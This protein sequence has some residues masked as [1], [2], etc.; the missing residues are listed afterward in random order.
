MRGILEDF[1]RVTL[2][3]S[4]GGGGICE[5]IGRLNYAYELQEEAY[6]LGPYAP[7]KIK[8]EPGWYLK[9]MYFD[10][11][12][13]H[14][15][16]AQMVI[17]TVGVDHVLYGSDAPPLTSL[18]PRAIKLI[19]DLDIPADGQGEDFRRQR[20]ALLLKLN[21]TLELYFVGPLPVQFGGLLA[22]MR[23]ASFTSSLIAPV[24]GSARP[25]LV[26][27]LG[28]H[29]HVLQRPGERDHVPFLE[30]VGGA[31]AHHQRVAQL[32]EIDAGGLG[33]P[34]GLDQPDG[35]HPQQQVV[36]GLA[37]L[38]VADVAQ[39]RIVGAER[40]I[41][42]AAALD[43]VGLAANERQQRALVGGEAA[44]ADRRV[45][46][47]DAFRLGRGGDLLHDERRGGGR[48][49][50]DRALGEIFEQAVLAVDDRVDLVGVADAE[51]DEVALL[52]ERRRRRR[53]RLGAGVDWR[54]STLRR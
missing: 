41:D 24:I 22:L 2:V 39:V 32:D 27:H 1:P 21:V 16:A 52:R 5:V 34:A 44:A 10:T 30:R 36:H 47:A 42:R 6:F 23:R 14:A 33:E 35:V 37:D 9:K 54:A 13:Y 25:G 20:G 11:V 29:L 49:R 43:H 28:H 38:A 4:H 40:R 31:G 26:G 51:D 19:E 46:H 45:E 12:T 18:K 48:H 53:R 7:M 15:P 3:S 17:D 50:D 8:H